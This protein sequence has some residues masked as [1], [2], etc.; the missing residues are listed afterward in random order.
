MERGSIVKWLLL[1]AAIFMIIQFGLPL[2]GIGGKGKT[3]VQPLGRPDYSFA[4]T[5]APEETCAIEGPRFKAELS[6]HGGSLRHFAV[7]SP[8]PKY[9]N[10]K[11]GEAIDLVSTSLEERMPLR[12][13]LRLPDGGDAAQ[14]VPV[15]DLD[16]KLE[17]QDGKSC[18]F[19]YVNSALPPK[20]VEP[21][22]TPPAPTVKVTKKV[23]A[24]ARPFELQVDV[25]VQ[26]LSGSPQ[27]HRLSVEQSAYRTQKETEGRLGLESEYLTETVAAGAK[28]ERQHPGDFEPD[29]FKDAVTAE[30]S[31]FTPEK[32]RRA[33]GDARFV[34]TS[35]S[36]F[37]SVLIPL[38]GPAPQA[39]TQ[40]EERW[41]IARFPKKT[42]DPSFGYVYRSRL[43]YPEQEV[44]PQDSKTYRTLAY[45]GPK[46]RD[47]L[48]QVGGG[49]H[50]ISDVI[51][52]GWFSAIGKILIKYIY[53]L[54]DAVGSWGWAICVLK[55][56]VKMGLFPLSWAQIKSSVAMRRLKPEMDVIN[57]KYKDDMAQRGLATQEL[58]RKH[59]VASPVM[60]CIPVMLQMPVWFA[61]YTALR[62]AVELYHTPFG[63]LIP[64]LAKPDKFYIIPV[65]LVISSFI[66][67]TL[68]PPQGDPAQQKM[69]KYMMPAIFGVMMLF[70]P[71]GLGVYMLTNTWLGITQQVLVERY[72]KS[73]TNVP[74]GIEVR[75]KKK[76]AGADDT[77][78]SDDENKASRTALESPPPLS[79][80]PALGKG[81]SRVRG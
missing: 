10:T 23:S 80:P 71:A 46:E 76:I 45:L 27:K 26:N 16:F 75:E 12:T 30:K 79:S 53:F 65:V 6:S 37:S 47:V 39:E 63:P 13:N 28:V 74:A 52:L 61:L 69:M 78:A 57:A 41:D 15:D 18:T 5:R 62:T 40:I 35:S 4:E 1:A 64:D 38:E 68:M 19:T 54:H 72:L 77:K 8:H 50:G 25:T 32:W 7:T 44:A 81:K 42:D 21:G 73:R 2:F 49:N 29:D 59:G 3:E 66:Q 9:I 67:Q 24:T 48:A 36:Y 56:T 33:L 11:T 60:G 43:A 58:W 31:G 17:A 14:A 22:A 20:D 70:L 55:I 34:A 51:D